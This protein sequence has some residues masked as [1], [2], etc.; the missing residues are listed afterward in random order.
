MHASVCLFYIEK[1]KR[2]LETTTQNV[3]LKKRG[4]LELKP[5]KA[6]F[7]ACSLGVVAAPVAFNGLVTLTLVHGVVVEG[8]VKS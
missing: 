3:F 7:F 5:V 6:R 4:T 8:R 1:N 2:V